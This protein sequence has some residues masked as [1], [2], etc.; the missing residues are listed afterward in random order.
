MFKRNSNQGQEFLLMTYFS[1]HRTTTECQQVFPVKDLGPVSQLIGMRL[2]LNY[3]TKEI[4]LD[5]TVLI[6]KYEALYP[7]V[8]KVSTHTLQLYLIINTEC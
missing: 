2:S 6:S 7:V 5:Q 3:N 8:R 4:L 1:L